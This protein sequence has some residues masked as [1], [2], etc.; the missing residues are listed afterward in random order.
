M[1]VR[2][3]DDAR[4]K[5]D[6]PVVRGSRVAYAVEGA[7]GWR[8]R[9]LFGRPWKYALPTQGID[10]PVVRKSW[11]AGAG[12]GFVGGERLK[13]RVAFSKLFPRGKEKAYD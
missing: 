9:A 12:E 2:W 3:W 6:L 4:R 11:G 8:S 10:L 1:T 7:G 13:L 5:V